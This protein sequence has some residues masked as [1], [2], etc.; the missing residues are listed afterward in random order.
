MFHGPLRIPFP[1]IGELVQQARMPF[2]FCPYYLSVPFEIEAGVFLCDHWAICKRAQSCYCRSVVVFQHRVYKLA[3]QF[4]F[5]SRWLY[6][7]FGLHRVSPLCCP[8]GVCYMDFWPDV[9]GWCTDFLSLFATHTLPTHQPG[10]S[11]SDDIPLVLTRLSC[12]T[13][14]GRGWRFLLVS[15]SNMRVCSAT[16]LPFCIAAFVSW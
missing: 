9:K 4:L 3:Y 14:G 1:R 15:R 5:I 13:I 8:C 7:V 16:R 11:A 2:W 12:H 10:S 6:R